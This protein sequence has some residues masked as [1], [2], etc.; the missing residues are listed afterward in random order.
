MI[1]RVLT[2]GEKLRIS[3]ARAALLAWFADH[4]RPLPWRHP[5][6]SEY[7]KI[8]VE[9]LLQRTQAR[10]V[11]SLYPA[12][13]A[14]FPNWQ[15]IAEAPVT[16]LEEM[17]KPV[18]LWRRRA[19]SIQG[20]ARYAAQRDGQLPSDPVELAKIPGVGQYVSNAIQL[21][22]HGRPRPLVDVNM[23][24][25]LERYLRPRVLAD[26]RHD[27]WLQAA[28]AWLVRFERPVAVNWAVLDHAALTC[29]ARTPRCESCVLNRGCNWRRAARLPSS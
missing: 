29:I 7:E 28:A 16:D 21:F 8:C 12:F 9:V 11:A 5:N 17:L 13:F 6:A 27:P 23:A 1:P 3:R 25:V 10:T 19:V 14:R 18:G 2:R 15:A 24:R 20:L 4:G 22:Q 26:I